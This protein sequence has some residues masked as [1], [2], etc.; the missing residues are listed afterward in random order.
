M[1]FVNLNREIGANGMS[2]RSVAAAVG[3]AE[4]TFRNKITSGNFTV[5]EAFLIRERVLPKYALEY[6][7]ERTDE[8]KVN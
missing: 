2:W 8:E 7:F 6:L 1:M 3:M 5:T 4:A